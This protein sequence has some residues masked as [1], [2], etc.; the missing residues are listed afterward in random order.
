MGTH[1]VTR[2]LT[3]LAAALF[4][5][6]CTELGSD[7]AAVVALELENV[8]VPAAVVGDTLRDTTGAPLALTAR[9]FNVQNQPV[10]DAPIRFLVLDT[11]ILEVDSITG[12]LVGK[13]VGQA[14]VI[15]SVQGLQS[16]RITVRV[17]LRPDT[18]AGLDSLRRSMQLS[19]TSPTAASSGPL[20]MFV[21]HDTTIA[22]RDTAVAVPN[23]LVRYRIV[24]PA[25]STVSETDTTRVVLANDLG[26]LST[27]DTTD[28]SGI[29]SRAVRLSTAVAVIPDSV[30]VEA[31]A[32]RPDGSALPGA[33]VRFVI[34]I[35]RVN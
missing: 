34:R 18:A 10:P 14:A 12:T 9:A 3:M 30:I 33:P 5:A 35:L 1:A 17:T 7:P 21:G 25:D 16:E 15:A 22:G 8:P 6:G 11:A 29:A 19:L 23:W 4:L 24:F 28:A 20:R 27:L 26:R 2:R 31:S 13:R 32:R